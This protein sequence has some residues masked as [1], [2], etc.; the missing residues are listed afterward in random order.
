MGGTILGKTLIDSGVGLLKMNANQNVS[1][2]LCGIAAFGV[3]RRTTKCMSSKIE[4]GE[5][6]K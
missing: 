6:V 3:T 1:E 4:K 5:G 2:Q